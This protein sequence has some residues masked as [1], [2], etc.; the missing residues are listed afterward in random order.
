L[1]GLVTILLVAEMLSDIEAD[2]EA[3]KQRLHMSNIDRR[4]YSA[5]T[6]E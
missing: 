4:I 6:L 1:N 3:L 2:E 5:Y